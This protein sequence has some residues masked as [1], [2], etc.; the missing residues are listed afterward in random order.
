[1]GYAELL[2]QRASELGVADRV[3]F[4]GSRDNV[5]EILDALDV[6]IHCPTAPE[7]FGRALAEAMAAARPVVAA[8]CGG[9]PE[10]VRDGETGYL[11]RPRDIGG[12]AARVVRL[13][14]DPEL[15]ARLG[16]AG[17]RR[18]EALFGVETHATRVLEAYASLS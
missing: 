1:V 4:L 18:A 3:F 5:P 8:D 17:R 13:L 7:P 15:R 2:R 12:F 14:R 10:I 16:T 9:I 11:V 6:L